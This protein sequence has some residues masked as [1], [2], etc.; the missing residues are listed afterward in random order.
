MGGGGGSVD[1]SAQRESLAIQREML[2][3]N[4]AAQE[5]QTE[6]LADERARQDA[7][8]RARAGGAWRSLLLNSEVGI[9]AAPMPRAEAAVG[10][11]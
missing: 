1:T 7:A 8:M 2:A 6:A 10:V 9:R 3:M 4:R 5:R 11:R